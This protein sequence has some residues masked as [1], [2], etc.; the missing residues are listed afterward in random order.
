M[1][2]KPDFKPAAKVRYSVGSQNT[3]HPTCIC[4]VAKSIKTFIKLRNLTNSKFKKILKILKLKNQFL[5]CH[6]YFPL[7]IKLN[8]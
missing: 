7:K 4:F 8:K 1:F 6:K 5:K 3:G 2:M